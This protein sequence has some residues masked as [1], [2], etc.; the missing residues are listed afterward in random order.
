MEINV[1]GEQA[2]TGLPERELAPL[3]DQFAARREADD[4]SASDVLSGGVE[5]TGLM[6]MAGWGTDV[7]QAGV[8][9]ARLRELRDKTRAQ[10][11]LELKQLS[12]GMS[13]DYQAAIA[14]GAT[15]VRIGSSLFEGV[16]P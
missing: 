13:G 2:K 14:E 15:M 12:M 5:I 6:A 3:L 7:A 1:S 11:G 16:L 4:S 9:F 10:T 8:Q